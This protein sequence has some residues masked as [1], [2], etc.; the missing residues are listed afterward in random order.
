[1][2]LTYDILMRIAF[3]RVISSL[4]KNTPTDSKAI[5]FY[6]ICNQI[7]S[8][9]PN[10]KTPHIRL[11]YKFRISYRLLTRYT[12]SKGIHFSCQDDDVPHLI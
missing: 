11:V 9:R 3:N 4:C 1:M 5:L 10:N 7:Q 6:F 8:Y 2:I 12:Y